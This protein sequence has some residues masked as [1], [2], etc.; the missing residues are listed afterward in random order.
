M[1]AVDPRYHDP[2]L[3]VVFDLDGTLVVS[4]HPYDKMRRETIRIAEQHGVPP[5]QLSPHQTIPSLVAT[6]EA[7]IGRANLPEGTRYR[8]EA[9]VNRRLDEIEV[10]GLAQTSERPGATALLEALTARGYRIGVLTRSCLA[11]TRGAL[12]KTSL[13]QYV[14]A[15]R[16]RSDPGPSKPESE[17]LLLL[18]RDLEVPADR[19][20]FVG[21]H[22]MD[23]ECA[24][25]AHVRFY[26]VLPV[27]PGEL[28]TDTERFRA[29]GATAVARDLEELGRQLGVRSSPTAVAAS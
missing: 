9:A 25:G 24:R 15:M 16:T 23:A 10:E 28:G 22:R 21:D 12:R 26:A 3:G 20:V 19:A 27:P 7:E 11:F 8:F 4:P 1:D 2:L 17:A 5:S 29:A 6:A 18:L 13:G 14:R